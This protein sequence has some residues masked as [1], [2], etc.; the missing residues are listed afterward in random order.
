MAK[1][2]ARLDQIVKAVAQKSKAVIWKTIKC[3]IRLK[4]T[5]ENFFCWF[6]ITDNISHIVV[7]FIVNIKINF[8][9][10]NRKKILDQLKTSATSLKTVLKDNLIGV[11]LSAGSMC[12]NIGN[13][14]RLETRLFTLGSWTVVWYKALRLPCHMCV[15]FIQ[16]SLFM[17]FSER[18]RLWLCH[19]G[20]P[21]YDSI[22]SDSRLTQ[23]GPLLMTSPLQGPF[24]GQWNSISAV[25]DWSIIM[26]LINCVFF[27]FF[28]S[29][30][31]WL[32]VCFVS[33][34]AKS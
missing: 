24:W 25:P 12:L 7:G 4:G 1:N 26:I 20:S 34:A 14:R 10:L 28:L 29:P 21:L 15:D 13:E 11:R 16:I 17:A 2:S 30:P 23:S 6:N 22:T 27:P 8:S 33:S 9:N 31:Q 18:P 3:F 19:G 32:G 5:S